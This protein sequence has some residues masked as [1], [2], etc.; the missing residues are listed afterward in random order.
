[1]L[2]TS[3]NR[4]PKKSHSQS[5]AKKPKK[6]K[7]KA[8]EVNQYLKG[9][10][11]QNTGSRRRQNTPLSQMN[12]ILCNIVDACITFDNT[13]MFHQPVK[14]KDAESYYDIIKNPMDLFTIK[15]KAKRCDYT[16]ISQ[17]EEDLKLLR[18]NSELYNGP[19]HF[20]TNQAVSILERADL[21]LQADGDQLKELEQ[22]VAD[23]NQF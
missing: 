5:G 10:V 19:N 17:F 21:L 4:T 16:H 2:D 23:G 13:G 14:K 9:P 11:R 6:P 1:M 18:T 12:E 3:D 20:V 15:S 7:P 22:K 8:P